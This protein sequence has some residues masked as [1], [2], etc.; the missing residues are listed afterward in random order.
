MNRVLLTGANGFLGTYI[1]KELRKQNYSITTLG[2]KNSIINIDL[3]KEV[4]LFSEN[5]NIVIHS[6]GKAHV[7][8]KT[9]KEK[10]DF[11][12]VNIQGTHNL[13]KSLESS[14][15]LKS[16][17]FISSVSV[18]GLIKG[19]DITEDYPLNAYD[20]YGKSKIEA[21]KLVKDF[22]KRKNIN[23][24]I[25]RLPLIAGKNPPGN[26]GSMIKSLKKGTYLSIGKAN[27]KKSMVMAEDVAKL[28]P[29]LFDKTGIYNLTDGYH[30]TFDELEKAIAVAIN[31]KNPLKI[32]QSFAWA[33][34]KTGDL[35]GNKSPINSE[36]LKKIKS[37]LT[38]SDKKAILELGWQ[39]IKVIDNIDKIL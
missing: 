31:K 11:F 38:F 9:E 19:N 21:E 14:T 28:I 36:K 30:P 32:H 17:I 35:L 12:L 18:Y 16:F 3:S 29:E 33:L 4:P 10:K 27:V 2:R 1:E 8:P 6:A 15:S 25:I 7:I 39:P 34:A 5:I 37:E 20:S 24:C 22:C 26:L 13:I 23:F